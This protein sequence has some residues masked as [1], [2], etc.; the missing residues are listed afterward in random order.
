ML[1][2][3]LSPMSEGSYAALRMVC[4]ATFALHGAQKILGVLTEKQPPMWSQVWFGG[5]IELVG[6]AMIALGLLTAWAAFLASG[7]MA[8]AYIQFH[9]K[10]KF[11]SN[12][13]PVVNKGESALLY[14]FLFLFIACRGSGPAGIDRLFKK[15][16]G[17]HS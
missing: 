17:Q 14:C 7:T 6:G 2:K 15:S 10:L 13:F 9:W 3:L 4:G 12:F 1:P 16:P 11:D 5:V 8:V